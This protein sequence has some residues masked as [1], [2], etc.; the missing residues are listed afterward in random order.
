MNLECEREREKTMNVK[1]ERARK[2]ERSREKKTGKERDEGKG[3]KWEVMCKT[4]SKDES[5]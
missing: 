3:E 5:I 4:G 2:G 1:W